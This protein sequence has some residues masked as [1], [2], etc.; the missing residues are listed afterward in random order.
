MHSSFVATICTA[1]LLNSLLCC[2]LPRRKEV[3]WSLSYSFLIQTRHIWSAPPLVDIRIIIYSSFNLYKNIP[4]YQQ[5]NLHVSIACIYMYM[6]YCQECYQK[7]LCGLR[8]KNGVIPSTFI[9]FKFTH[10]NCVMGIF[11][12]LDFV[13]LFYMCILFF[14]IFWGFV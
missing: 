2:M 1:T 10:V 12:V 7:Y 5:N 9:G 13:S 8:K 6:C 11:Y 4:I 14:L 3:D